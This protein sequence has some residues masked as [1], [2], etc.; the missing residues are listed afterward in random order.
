M[1]LVNKQAG[2]GRVWCLVVLL[3]TGLQSGQAQIPSEN[4]ISRAARLVNPGL[5]ELENRLSWLEER[6]RT[7]AKFNEHPLRAGIGARGYRAAPADADPTLVVDLGSERRISRLFLVPAQRESLR[8]TGIFPRQFTIDVD[9]VVDFTNPVVI[10]ATGRRDFENPQGRPIPFAFDEVT[11]RYVRLTV[12]RGHNNKGWLDVFGLS[13]IVVM[14]GDDVV[15]FGASVEM[16]NSLSSGNNWYPSALTDGRMPHGIWHSGISGMDAGDLVVDDSRNE[17]YWE[18]HL[19]QP[20]AVDRVVLFPYSL[21]NSTEANVA[22]NH[23]MVKCWSPD[24]GEWELLEEWINRPSSASCVT[25]IVL[26]IRGRTMER[27]RIISIEPWQLGDLHLHALSE[28]EIWSGGENL[29]RSRPVFR[30]FGEEYVS[31]M[32]LTDGFTSEHLV[33]NVGLWLDQLH[34]RLNF[35][36]ELE[37]LRPRIHA[38]EA[39]SELN[40]TFASA[41][42]LGFTFM[43]PV[44]LIE[45]RRV[46][47]KQ[48]VEVMRRRIASDLHDDIG[49][50]LGSISL[51]ARSARRGL[52]KFSAPAEI[53]NDLAEVEIIAQQS[54][55]AMRDII[56]LIEQHDDS[57]GDLIARMQETCGRMLRDIEH[58]FVCNSRRE[59]SR[60]SLDFKRHF[61]LFFKEALH[62]IQKHSRAG[63]VSILMDDE[64]DDLI[65][66]IRD[67]G[68]GMPV[69]AANGPETCRKLRQ[70]AGMIQGRMTLTSS[71]GNGTCVRLAI[72]TKKFNSMEGDA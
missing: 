62:N 46:N 29:A 41:I 57:V 45:R 70:R 55:M 72:C 32:N 14:A 21:T 53:T 64:K 59:D 5:V 33:A 69:E 24:S 37:D 54:S 34:E 1:K 22:S 11:A 36:N 51:I 60:L 39:E 66:E 50:N 8:D 30:S 68:V 13:E 19:D 65:L 27:I 61:Y 67:D 6:T 44:F 4:P 71:P 10:H 12:H 26:P 63:R 56:W 43:I 16:S 38:I 58:T 25:P 3:L 52:E 47:S 9:V 20:A 28:I 2:S 40:V 18:I 15:S 49:G 7:M 31:L 35:E 48:R 17:I 42:L 23:L